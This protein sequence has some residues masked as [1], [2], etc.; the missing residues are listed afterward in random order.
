MNKPLVYLTGAGPGDPE[1]LT[2]KAKRVIGEADVIVYDSLISTDL[3]KYARK[4]CE[5]IYAGKRSSNH[6]LPQYSINELLAKKA[7]ENK[8]VVRLKG[9]DPF[10]Y[11][12]GGEEAEKLHEEG[13]DFEIIPGISSS[14]A[15]PAYAGIPLT[16][17]D[18]S[19]T[20]AIVTGHEGEHK[21][22]TTINWDNIAGAS[23]IVV[24]MGYKNIANIINEIIKAG[25]DENTPAAVIQEGTTAHQ[26]VAVGTLKT[27]EKEM[28]SEGLKSP[29]I[30]TSA[31]AAEGYFERIFSAGK[32][33][34]ILSNC[35][36]ISVG[37]A[38][39]AELRK[40]GIIADIFPSS[41]EM[42]SQDGII[43]ELNMLYGAT[44]IKEKNFLFPQALNINGELPEYIISNGGALTNIPVYE[45]IL[46]PES[47]ENIANLFKDFDAA[48]PPVNLITFTSY[49]TV[50]N[51]MQCV[52]SAQEGLLDILRRTNADGRRGIRFAAIG[53]KTAEYAFRFG[54]KSDI[55]SKDV[56]INSL[57]EEIVNFYK[58]YNAL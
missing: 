28:R 29:L 3:L 2:L 43:K 37:A 55:I 46:P 42:F 47:I 26:K 54:I 31:N 12:R 40:Y 53:R 38:T 35:K 32:D 21:E 17:R 51:F 13:I 33:L 19:S 36:I 9:G 44:N 52:E 7:K 25:K 34:R 24:L 11:G 30:F 45:T 41:S 48:N 10:L 39:M 16:H 15:V 49:S 50:E 27:I 56:N 22:E 23:T 6:T 5:I 4:D 57:T 18:Y 14:F 20:V 8:I 1:L 58:E